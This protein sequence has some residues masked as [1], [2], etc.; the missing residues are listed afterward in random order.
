MKLRAL[1][2]CAFAASAC[3]A[4]MEY[5]TPESQGVDS[6][7]ILN[8]IDA[9]EKTFDGVKEGRIHGF[10]IVRHGKT[11][12]EGSWKPFDTLNETHMLYSHSKSFTSSAVGFLVDEGKIDLDERIVDIF[13]D[14]LP[15][16]PSDNLRQLR[17]RDLL[18]MNVGKKDHLLRDGGD[19]VREFLSKDF[20]K[21]PGT[22][23]RYDSDATYMLSAIVEKR[24]G[25]KL[26][27]F[28]KE[29]MFG[30]IGISSAWSTTSPQG[31]ACGGW[32]MNMTTRDIARFGQLYL[33]QGRWGGEYVL[34]PSWVAL[35]TTRHTWSGW[36][37]IGVKA[38]GEGSDWEQGYGFQFWRCRHGAYRADGASGQLTVVLPECDMV[39]S[40]NAGLRDMQKELALIWDNLLPGVKGSPLVAGEALACLRRR[41]DA[42]AIPPTAGGSAGLDVFLGKTYGFKSNHRGIE[43]ARFEKDGGNLVCIL[44]VPAGEQ[45]IPVGIGEWKKGEMRFDVQDYEFLGA[46]VGV[47]K[48]AASAGIG[49][50]GTLSA[51]IYLTGDTGYIDLSVSPA[52]GASGDFFAMNGTKLVPSEN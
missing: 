2:A 15:A 21:K 52:K 13:P 32:G 8:W 23:F 43:S 4:E 37:N 22:G 41:I 11:I 25:K 26:M 50:D 33:Q 45:K 24:T 19:W 38:L 51:R 20:G 1:V 36:S 9:C 39:V 35:A 40:I 16:N 17:V 6:Q 18:T 12:A 27:D 3:M 29:R 34:S 30:K 47:H 7:A 5:A 44:K 14:E 42:L 31:I 10:V 28:L 49:A 48:T 46:Y